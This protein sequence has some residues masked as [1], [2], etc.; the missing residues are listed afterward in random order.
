M[1]IALVALALVGALS[2]ARAQTGF[3]AY[4]GYDTTAENP[5]LGVG[6]RFAVP[7]SSPVLLSFQPAVEY[8]F[9]ENNTIVQGDFNL[10][11]EYLGGGAVVPYAGAGLNVYH[12]DPDPELPAQ[13]DGRTEAGLNL[14]FGLSFDSGGY[15]RP[16]VHGQLSTHNESRD[17]FA[18]KGGITFG[19]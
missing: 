18:L 2:E 15:V 7:L 17:A 1:R 12:R 10:V 9:A 8:H 11:G 16:F 5:L 14:L 19:L 13:R 4:G 3:L 6:I